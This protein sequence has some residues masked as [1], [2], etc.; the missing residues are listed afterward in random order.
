MGTQTSGLD[1][2]PIGHRVGEHDAE[3]DDVDAGLG[4]AAHDAERGGVVGIA[5]HGESDEACAA[6]LA[7]PGETSGDAAHSLI[8]RAAATVKTSLSP[9]PQRFMTSR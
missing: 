7:Q 4:Q 6:F 1:G 8:P 3:L 2:R 9:R 5:G